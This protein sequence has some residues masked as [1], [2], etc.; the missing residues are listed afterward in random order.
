MK[1]YHDKKLITKEEKVIIFDIY[2]D[3]VQYAHSSHITR[4]IY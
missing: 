1:I 4:L 2:K 3:V